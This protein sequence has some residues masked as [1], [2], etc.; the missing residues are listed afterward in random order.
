MSSNYLKFFCEP[1]AGWLMPVILAIQEAVIRRIMVQNQLQ[2][3]SSLDPISK[4]TTQKKRAV[5]VA[6]VIESLVSMRP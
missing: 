3:Y 1:G 2:A 5:G 6:Q 4:K